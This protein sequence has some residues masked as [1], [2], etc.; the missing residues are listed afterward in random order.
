MNAPTHF[1]R[2]QIVRLLGRGA[3]GLVYEGLDPKLNRSVAIK[4]VSTSRID[5]QDQRDAYSARFEQEAQAVARMNHPNIVTVYDFGEQDGAAYL[6]MELV[7]GEQLGDYFEESQSFQLEF[8][9]QDSVRMTCEL[10]DAVG[11]AHQHGVIHRDIKPANVMLGAGFKVKLA[12]FGV[13]R[14]ADVASSFDDNHMVGTPSFMSPEQIGGQPAGP[15]SDIFAVG[16]ILYQFL[17]TERPFRGRGPFAVQQRI[18]YDEPMPPSLINPLL[19]PVFDRIVARALAK[20]PDR[21]YAHAQAFKDDLERALRG[22][23]LC[24]SEAAPAPPIHVRLPVPA[25]RGAT[26]SYEDPDA[27]LYDLPAASQTS[28]GTRP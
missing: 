3:M 28:K 24:A 2:Y 25:E 22:E 6:V 7:C 15:R 10:L 19:D 11:Y 9:L 14:M 8:T 21:R 4:V 12:D 16:I 20:H 23:A 27:T 1:G 13:A 18:L 5:G 17:T 26:P